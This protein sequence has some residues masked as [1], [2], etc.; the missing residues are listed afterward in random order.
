MRELVYQRV[1]VSFALLL[2]VTVVSFWLTVGDGAGAL[3][4]R[5]PI[6]WTQVVVLA[7]VKVRWVMLDFMELRSAPIKMR[8]LC[9]A[10][11]AS[12]AAV[13]VATAWL[14]H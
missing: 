9:E 7:F 6:I 1:T 12:L 8:A 10:W 11:G 2:V 4:E 3:N 13:L 14:V 5:G